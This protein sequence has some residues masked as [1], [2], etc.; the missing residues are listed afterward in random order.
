MVQ[1]CSELSV[2][3]NLYQIDQ[4]LDEK[5]IVHPDV[6]VLPECFASMGGVLAD[7]TKKVVLIK[8]WMREQARSYG[9]WVVGGTVPYLHQHE[10]KCRASC[11]VYDPQGNERVRYDKIHLFDAR[12]V[13]GRG[14]YQESD[15]YLPGDTPTTISMEGAP[16]R[17]LGLSVCYDLRFPEL[18]RALVDLGANIFCIPSAFTHVTGKAHWEPLLRARA[19]ENQCIVIAANQGGRHADGRET[20]GHSMIISPWGEILAEAGTEPTVLSVSIDLSMLYELRI[21]MPF[22]DHRRL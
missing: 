13:D 19:I 12:V 10:K 20:W 7:V 9:C 14:V 5:L 6:L 8:E 15:D 1:T 3:T 11:F 16:F 22:Y 2:D 18:Y 21:K 4:L 17:C